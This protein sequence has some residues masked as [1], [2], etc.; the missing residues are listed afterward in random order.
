MC[1]LR[2]VIIIFL[3]LFYGTASAWAE[4]IDYIATINGVEDKALK[5]N[6][7][8]K[9]LLFKLSD[10][11][12]ET[13][14][15]LNRR[16][17]NDLKALKAVM[18][19]SGYYGA[20]LSH[21]MTEENGKKQIT[22]IVEQGPVYT[23][24][25]FVLHWLENKQPDID[26]LSILKLPVGEAALPGTILDTEQAI[27]TALMQNGF[28][29]PQ[30]SGRKL[31]VRHE[32]NSV[33]VEL[34]LD[35]G[36]TACFGPVQITG[37]KK[38]DEPFVKRRIKWREGDVFDIEKIAATRK[39]LTRSGVIA[40]V[41]I[42]YGD[43]M[44]DGK[45]PVTLDIK[46]SKRRSVG[47]GV[48]YSTTLELVGNVFWEHRN[49]FGQAERLRVKVEGGTATYSLGADLS[50]PDIFGNIDLS[51]QNSVEFRQEFLEAFDKDTA[52]ISTALN[53]KYSPTSA[54]SGGVTVERSRIEENG[55]PDAT[56]TLVSLPTTYRYDGTDDF[57]NPREGMRFNVGVT[58]YQIL[59]G[60]DSFIKT[61]A[62]AS[63][64][65]PVGERF[66]WANRA[67]AA[68]IYGQTLD[69]IPADKR[70]YAGGGG[71]VRGYGYQLLGPLDE[72]NNPTGGRMAFEVG[73]EGRFQITK[74]IEGVGFLEGG[75]LSEDME[76]KSN[77]DFLWGAGSGVRYHTPIGPLRVDVAVPLDKRTPDDAFQFYISLGQAF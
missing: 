52:S 64:Y 54:V 36:V 72:D 42:Q 69:D 73:T 51:W 45:I 1:Y 26:V 57:L 43:I 40:S 67:R 19:E 20:T 30:A 56:F 71:S 50:K 7:E 10:K 65:W 16:I 49:L 59:N 74:T 75:R 53:Y 13:T 2:A 61:D 33:S 29:L 48:A 38:L 3:F 12:P 28:P 63:H 68:V 76:F 66:V 15:A 27:L 37:L 5:A 9:S 39:G 23:I 21:T 62:G 35:P 31:F 77:A 46:E 47:A 55:E 34:F 8:E 4:G 18:K 24:S 60:Q 14:A 41:D 17:K 25:E 32:N 58:P 22:L 6:L 70:L 11:H 44:E